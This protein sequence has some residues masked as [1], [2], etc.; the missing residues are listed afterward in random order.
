MTTPFVNGRQAS[1][2]DL[3]GQ[4]KQQ[5][6]LVSH[7]CRVRYTESTT[8]Q[9]NR[10]F[11][12]LFPKRSGDQMLDCRSIRL[13]FNL[14]IDSSDLNAS[15]GAPDVRAIFNRIRI[16]SGTT[17]IHDIAEA[18]LA[19]NLETLCSVSNMDSKYD[20]RVEGVSLL[21]A[22]S[23]YYRHGDEFIVPICPKGGLLNS[24]T[25]LPTSRMSDLIWECYLEQPQRCMFA[26]TD[27]N[28]TYSIENVEILCDYIHSPSISTYFN[29]HGCKFHCTDV[30]TRFNSV[31]SQEHVL[32][33]SSSHSSLNG[34]LTAYRVA[35]VVTD[36]AVSNKFSSFLPGTQ[37]ERY[38]V[39]VNN[40]LMYE[41][42][43]DSLPMSWGFMKDLF[44]LAQYSI[45][46]DD[47]IGSKNLLA[48]SI[49]SS[50]PEFRDRIISGINTSQL[51]SDITYRV[52]LTAQPSVPLRTDSFL[53]SDIWV[54]LPKAN[55]DL[56]VKF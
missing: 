30:A 50:P 52:R 16:L 37:R 54:F 12:L 24:D 9:A 45:W 6:D 3:L 40:S 8:V 18:G 25:L 36:I 49:I 56:Q 38:N 55:S 11:R 13:K 39:L 2:M 19:F 51:N 21:E 29:Q 22:P 5:S 20:R 43:I 33:L 35:S 31:L 26:D 44:P 48:T 27:P 42:D 34:I 1:V 14:R 41:Q 47:F 53:Y 23:Y 32:R 7:Q 4:S 46:F 15:I 28:A 17:V 10:F